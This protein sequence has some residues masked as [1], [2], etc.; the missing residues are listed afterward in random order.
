MFCYLLPGFGALVMM[1]R[2][3]AGGNRLDFQKSIGVASA[4]VVG[5]VLLSLLNA[6]ARQAPMFNS[7]FLFAFVIMLTLL[8]YANMQ[9]MLYDLAFI[10]G[11]L[12]R[13]VVCFVVPSALVGVLFA[14]LGTTVGVNASSMRRAWKT[15]WQSLTTRASLRT[16]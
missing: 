15:T 4:V 16:S 6:A 5:W 9:K 14:V 10:A 12:L 2:A 8:V 13:L 1:Q 11:Q 7:L 3:E